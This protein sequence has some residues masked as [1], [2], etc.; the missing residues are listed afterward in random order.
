[1]KRLTVPVESALHQR[2][3]ILSA[4]TGQPMGSIVTRSLTRELEQMERM[5]PA[6]TTH[7]P[8]R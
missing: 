5:K 2:L 3:K 6:A 4:Q 8:R 1:M 7:A